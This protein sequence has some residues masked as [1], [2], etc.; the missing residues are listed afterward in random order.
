MEKSDSINPGKS[1]HKLKIV[2]PLT[3]KIHLY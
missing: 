1:F 3:S 2:L